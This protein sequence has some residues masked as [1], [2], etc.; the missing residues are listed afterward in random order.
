LVYNSDRLTHPLRRVGPKGSGQFERISW[1]EA[2]NEIAQRFQSIANGA[3]GPQAILP[4]SY[5]GTMGKI[6]SESL[7]RRFFHRLGASLL[8]RTIC[9]TAGSTGYRYTIGSGQGTDPEAFNQARHIINWGSN[10]AVTNVHLWV[11]MHEAR[12]RGAKIVTIDPY[13]SRTAARSDWHIAPR[14]GTDAALALGLMHV[15]FRDDLTDADYLDRYCLGVDELRDR[16]RSQYAPDKVAGITGLD[17]DTIEKLAR[18]YS[19]TRPSVIRVNYGIQRHRGGGMAVRTI[20][21]LPA[22]IGAWRERAGGILLSTSA[23]F[24]LNLQA[25]Q[26]PDLI[27]ADTRT[28]NMVQLGEALAGELPGPPVKALYVYN[29]NPAAIAPN[30]EKVLQGLHRDDLFT[31]V[32]EQFPTDTADYADIVLPVTTQLEH[33]DLHA[34]YGHQYVQLN[35]PVIAPLSEARCNTDVFRGLATRMGFEKNLFEVTDEDLA[36]EALWESAA[37]QPA[38]LKGVTVE[39][40]ITNGPAKLSSS[41]GDTP[42]AEGGFSTP[43]GRCEFFSQTMADA[44][45]DPLPTYLPPAEDAT[46]APEL[47]DKYPLQLL[48]PPSPH[49]LNSSFVNVS[50]LREAAGQPTL[51]IHPTD[52]DQRSICDGDRVCIINDRG[53]FQA[54]AQVGE[55]VRLGVVVAESIWWNKYAPGG[56]NANA[57]TSSQLTDMGGGAT[58]FDNLVQVQPLTTNHIHAIRYSFAF[59]PPGPDPAALGNR[60]VGPRV[61]AAYSRSAVLGAAWLVQQ[62]SALD[63]SGHRAD[64]CQLARPTPST[65]RSSLV[66]FAAGC[67]VFG[68]HSLLP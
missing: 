43:S 56:R 63:G 67:A 65:T 52:A 24:P 64:H 54:I 6:Q 62:P 60:P 2:L 29:S 4:Y 17:V 53:S 46:S 59:Q 20:A 55:T 58:F 28:I 32:H 22:V 66:A 5:C 35:R 42:F 12:K 16:V 10:T 8:D 11:R 38:A 25:L 39:S 48:S 40:L 13:R 36:R 26:R 21:C 1:N 14:P 49:F 15:L 41:A 27:P 44:G 9:A 61:S 3:H 47:A 7:D 33:F 68:C 23:T 31:V 30:Q 37:E 50:S 34:S 45:F 51:Q 57:T 18:E 19:T